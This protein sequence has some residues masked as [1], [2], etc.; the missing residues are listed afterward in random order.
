M[1]QFGAVKSGCCNFS[2]NLRVGRSC[3]AHI[4]VACPPPTTRASVELNEWKAGCAECICTGGLR[5]QRSRSLLRLCLLPPASAS[6]ITLTCIFRIPHYLHPCW[7]FLEKFVSASDTDAFEPTLKLISIVSN[8]IHISYV[9]PA[10][11]KKQMKKKRRNHRRRRSTN[12]NRMSIIP[13]ENE[14]L[15]TKSRDEERSRCAKIN[16][17]VILAVSMR[18]IFTLHWITNMERDGVNIMGYKDAKEDFFVG[19]FVLV[20]GWPLFGL[21]DREEGSNLRTC[22]M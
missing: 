1:C 22:R 20:N 10:A 13:D 8:R 18:N 3:F 7:M 5:Q 16:H 12:T 6:A 21:Y 11:T 2:R 15:I 19:V 4:L 17:D 14:P 9:S